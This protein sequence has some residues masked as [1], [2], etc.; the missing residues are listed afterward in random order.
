M[1]L[2]HTD[3]Y[4]LMKD[5]ETKKLLAT[6]VKKMLF[7]KVLSKHTVPNVLICHSILNGVW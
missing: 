1:S 4:L 7:V 6:K 5:H 3:F 2:K